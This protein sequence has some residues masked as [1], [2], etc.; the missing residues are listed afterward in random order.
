MV[1]LISHACVQI[2]NI[3][4]DPWLFGKAFNDSWSLI[5]EAGPIHYDSVEYLWISHEHPDHFHVPTLKALPA[6][7]KERVTVLFQKSSNPRKM[8][9]ALHRFGFR[10]VRLLPHRQWV[11]LNG[12]E[13]LCYQ[14]RQI[15]SALSVR[16]SGGVIL[17]INDCDLSASDLRE[18][19]RLVGPP[20]V[21]LNQ[22]SLAGFD[23]IE[24]QLRARSARILDDMVTA[25][26]ILGAKVTVPF[27][28]FAH[29]CCEDNAFLNQ[30]ANS[31]R[32]VADRFA[33]DGLKLKALRHGAGLGR[34]GRCAGVVGS[35][36]Y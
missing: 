27:A 25:H 16:S 5:A 22:L 9:A 23:G 12:A 35:G 15:D 32:M 8:V 2:G 14:S 30:F 10:K 19:E 28:S 17:N 13:V 11:R 26:R 1:R 24:S 7:F 36:H 6:P 33:E 4:T 18:I 21:L 20:D 31:P 29:F 3:L 34:T